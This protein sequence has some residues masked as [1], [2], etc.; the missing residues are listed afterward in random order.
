MSFFTR[1]ELLGG[2]P[3]K[4]ASTLLFA[5]E[6]RTAH[7]V[8]QAKQVGARYL[9]EQSAA[10]QEQNFLAAL[11]HARTNEALAKIQD[12]E[13]YAAEWSAL[14]PQEAGVRAVLAQLLGAKYRFRDA[15]VPELRRVL[16][17]DTEAVQQA[18]QKFYGKPLSSIY[19]TALAAREK[20]AWE[21]SRFAHRID[22]LPP[23]WTAF[24]LT[25]TETVGAGILALPIAFAAM[26]PLAGVVLLVVFALVNILTI[27]AMTE[28]IVRNGNMRY[29]SNYFGRMMQDYF[30]AI[31]VTLLTLSLGILNLLSLL[32]Y[33]I[34]VAS[35]MESATS[36]SGLFWAALLFLVILYFLKRGSIEATAASALVIGIVNLALIL[37]LVGMAL[38]HVRA[39]YMQFHA[40]GADMSSM[41]SVIFG[42]AFGVVLTTFF[43]HTSAANAAKVVLRRDPSGSQLIWGNI[44]ALA[45]A[46]LLYMIWTIA[47]NGS[48][49]PDALANTNGTVLVPMANVI[50]PMVYVAGT[51]FIILAMGMSAV[52]VALGLYYS[53]REQLPQ[54]KPNAPALRG[55]R[56]R[57]THPQI[58]FWIGVAPVIVLFIFGEWMLWSKQLSFTSIV[59]FL[60]AL[61]TPI[62]SGIFP[63][64]LLVAS[65]R[66]ADYLAQSGFGWLGNPV[67]VTL[68]YL[69]FLIGIAMQALLLPDLFARVLAIVVAVG[70]VILPFV[71]WRRG[72]FVARQVVELRVSNEPIE[73]A[74]FQ[75]VADGALR[76]AKIDLSYRGEQ[77][78]LNAAQGSVPNFRALE[79]IKIF[80]AASPAREIKIWTH[81]VNPEGNSE[82]LNM[83]ATVV[84]ADTT[85]VLDMPAQHGMVILPLNENVP[86]EISLEPKRA[87]FAR[88]EVL[89]A[90]K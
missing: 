14:V 88:A 73:Q 29:G 39:E 63:M 52:F 30:G 58:S 6:S 60:G 7:L 11:A 25:L 46:A 56:A 42:V 37:I 32:A 27:I 85:R 70:M 21:Q 18:F 82:S 2:L 38:P 19:Q 80:L 86:V 64:L 79:R 1:D 26:G 90:A 78:T 62:F 74:A 53:V 77:K 10:E 3:A 50:G 87:A 72:A 16:G 5:I 9:T 83:Q 45:V 61:V 51:L 36:I 47:V 59:G 23:F 76:A 84:V 71:L 49:A 57:L 15:D 48:I 40:T 17:L 69:V 24:A 20:V 13:R 43:G 28:A 34:G 33:L 89:S 35:T 66:K 68:V 8:L 75:M 44:V 4:R 12:L 81:A 65:R 67:V 55:W 22:R 31:G 54:N 41:V